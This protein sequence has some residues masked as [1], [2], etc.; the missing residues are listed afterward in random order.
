MSD[1]FIAIQ[2]SREQQPFEFTSSKISNV[3]VKK[4]DTGDYSVEGLE[5]ILC[6][7]RKLN[8]GE[9]YTNITQKRFWAEMERMKAYKYRFLIFEFSVSDIE[10]FPYG[11]GLPKR[12]MDKLKISSA[13]LMK[14]VARI[15]VEYEIDV[16]FGGNRDNSIYLVTNIMKEVY[17][18]RNKNQ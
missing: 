11:A 3:I 17:E 1:K 16:V 18:R 2:D 10:M 9:F 15:Q 6:I 5:D 14:C 12:V 4:L 13:Y 8:V 7:E